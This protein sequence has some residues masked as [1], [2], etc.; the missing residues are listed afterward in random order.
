MVAEVYDFLTLNVYLLTHISLY[1]ELPYTLQ[2]KNHAE[3]MVD[4]KVRIYV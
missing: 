2:K 4:V 3:K 1:L